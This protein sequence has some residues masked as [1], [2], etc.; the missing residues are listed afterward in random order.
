MDRLGSRARWV[1]ELL[2]YVAIIVP[3]IVI[4]IATLIFDYVGFGASG[5]ELR[6][7]VDPAAQVAQFR[8]ALDWLTADPRIDASRLGVW[9]PSMAGGHTLT[10]AAT[11]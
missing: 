3:G 1:F 8:R 7:H 2:T 6:Q 11:V 5:G 10:L 9:G 4:G